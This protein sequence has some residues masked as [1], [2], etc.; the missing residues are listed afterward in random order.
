MKNT[1]SNISQPLQKPWMHSIVLLGSY[2]P[3]T[4]LLTVYIQKLFLYCFS[5]EFPLHPCWPSAMLACLP[6]HQNGPFSCPKEMV[7]EDQPTLL[8]PFVLQGYL[9][10]DSAKYFHE[11]A[12]ISSPD[13]QG[14]NSAIHLHRITDYLK[15]AGM[16]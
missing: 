6:A 14:C 7:L 3:I 10:G 13:D 15:F 9:P 8:D 5:P 11:K 1:S 4:V 16:S 2:C 12:W